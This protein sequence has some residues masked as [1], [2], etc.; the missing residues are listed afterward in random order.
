MNTIARQ[1]SNLA[2][3]EDEPIKLLDPR[4][5]GGVL[6]YE[7]G[8][9]LRMWAATISAGKKDGDRPTVTKNGVICLHEDMGEAP[10]IRAA[11]EATKFKSVTITMLSNNIGDCLK[12]L[13]CSYG[14]VKVF[15]DEKSLTAMWLDDQKKQQRKV[16]AAGDPEFD[17]YLAMCKASTFVPFA[18]AAWG[19]DGNP[20]LS[21]PDGFIPYRL[22]FGSLN[23]ARAFVDSLQAIK[24]LTQGHLMGVPLVL[25]IADKSVMTPELDRR[26]VPVWNLVLKHP[27]GLPMRA[28]DIQ[29]VLTAGIRDAQ[30][31]ALPANTDFDPEQLADAERAIEQQITEEGEVVDTNLNPGAVKVAVTGDATETRIADYFRAMQNTPYTDDGV[32]ALLVEKCANNAGIVLERPSLRLLAEL[33]TPDEWRI[34]AETFCKAA[35][36]HHGTEQTKAARQIVDD[37]NPYD[38]P[39]KVDAKEAA[40]DP[41]PYVP[42]DQREVPKEPA[43]EAQPETAKQAAKLPTVKNY[44]TVEREPTKE[45]ADVAKEYARQHLTQDQFMEIGKACGGIQPLM[46]ML[47]ARKLGATSFGDIMR[48]VEP[49]Y[50]DPEPEQKELIS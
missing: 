31:M 42:D 8:K 46:V 16:V 12:Q 19:E 43:A 48:V 34:C 40:V 18:L 6:E 15:G 3:Y 41:T 2:S 35:A 5:K 28:A 38:D 25:S 11:L 37:A 20:G 9:S 13:F 21:W 23:S 22:R 47:Q 14:K 24:R 50:K 49:G 27:S 33:A 39:P 30:Q 29:R 1:D 45:E 17:K 44:L 36:E 10:G 7:S 4:S 26:K 32:R